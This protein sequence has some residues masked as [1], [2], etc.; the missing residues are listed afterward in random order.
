MRRIRDHE[1]IAAGLCA[2]AALDPRLEA[3]IASAGEVPLRLAEP[4][5]ASLV[6]IIVSQ[7]V[8][9]ASADA[10]MARLVAKVVP[11]DAPTLVGVGDD[12]WRA[13]GLSRPKQKTLTA[14][15]RAIVEDGLDLGR[16]TDLGEAEAMASLTALHGV[17]PWT[18][19]VYLL[20]CAGHP[21]IFPAH[22]VALQSAVGH[23]LGIEPRPG[24]KALY[25]IAESWAPWR[26]VAARLFW[27]YYREMRGGEAAILA[28][29]EKMQ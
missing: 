28:S 23:A 29:A 17:G 16:L 14:L 5:L 19:E 22:D 7:Q 13:I 27:A 11:L 8:S 25:R 9:R 3:V 21:D 12:A 10:I 2:L 20:F 26:G 18:A 15:S 4:G 24:A 6:S 1:D